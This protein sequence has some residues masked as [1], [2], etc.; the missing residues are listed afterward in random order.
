MSNNGPSL[1]SLYKRIDKIG[2]GTYGVVY[3]A[4]NRQTGNYV[5]LKQISMDAAAGVPS[6]AIREVSL[7]K[8]LYHPNIVQLQDIIYG[9]NCLHLVFEHIQ[10][11][12]KMFIDS[13]MR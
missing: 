1:N 10:Q 11:D 13:R 4:E 12:L 6:T 9:Q 7:L 2:E 5:A 8:E 3:I